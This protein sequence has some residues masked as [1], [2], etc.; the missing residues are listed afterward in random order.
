MFRIDPT[1]KG[2]LHF[3]YM[4]KSTHNQHKLFV[5]HAEI[6]IHVYA[7]AMLIDE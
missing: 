5:V 7:T 1:V 3:K 4:L 6:S 2:L